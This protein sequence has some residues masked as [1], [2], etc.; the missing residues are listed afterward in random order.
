MYFR[1]GS[2]KFSFIW[3]V[4]SRYLGPTRNEG[5]EM[6]MWILKT[7]VM[8]VPGT[9]LRKLTPGELHSDVELSKRNAFDAN[10][11]LKLGKS[12]PSLRR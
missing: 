12:F 6:T 2:Q 8:I 10:V 9:G 5:N 4:L 1:D 3:E 11:H 7:N